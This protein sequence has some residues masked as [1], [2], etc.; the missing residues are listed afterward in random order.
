M[1]SRDLSSPLIGQVRAEEE[2]KETCFKQLAVRTQ[3]ALERDQQIA[4]L[5]S[6]VT[7]WL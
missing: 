1:W 3:E 7:R 4:Q 6:Q 2:A 5:T